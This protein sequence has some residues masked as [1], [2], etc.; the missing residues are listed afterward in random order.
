MNYLRVKC[1]NFVSFPKTACAIWVEIRSRLITESPGMSNTRIKISLFL[2]YFLFAILLNSVGSVILQSQRYFKLQETSAAMI[3]V[4]KDL[5]IAVV[6]FGVASFV[7]RIGYKRSMLIAMGLMAMVCFLIPTLKSFLAL[8]ILFSVTGACFALI[9]VSVLGTIGL[10]TKNKKDHLSLMNFIESVFM[11]GIFTGYLLFSFF[12]NEEPSSAAWF[13]IY[14]LFGLIA[15]FAFFLLLGSTL[16]ESPVRDR[17]LD[18]QGF[19]KSMNLRQ[20]FLPMVISFMICAFAYV[21]AEQSIMSWLSTFNNKVLEMST[22]LSILLTG[23]LA[24]SMAGGRFLSGMMMKRINWFPLLC[25]S[26]L[27]AALLI[28][29]ALPLT[30]NGSGPIL[31]LG[32][33]FSIPLVGLML[34]A[35]GF[36][37][38]PLYPVM[39][40]V[41]LSSMPKNSHGILSGLIVVFSALGGILGSFI[42]GMM[43]HFYGGQKAFY[44]LLIPIVI[45]LLTLSKLNR[46]NRTIPK[47]G[48]SFGLV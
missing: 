19:R 26:L 6:S 11:L 21:L 39:N 42:T 8:E 38:A 25:G 18:R 15:V 4:C 41:F 5:S 47:T 24:A 46:L 28:L 27:G 48:V 10:I 13:I 2:N 9:K 12:V 20:I 43:F 23:L 40:S 30:R 29:I 37:L 22:S 44:M 31:N 17:L 7:I 35:L 36:F 32:S 1:W 34:P 14:Y 3:E 16:D 45:L 33:Y